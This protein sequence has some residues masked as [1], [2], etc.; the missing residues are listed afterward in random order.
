MINYSFPSAN[1]TKNKMKPILPSDFSHSKWTFP[2]ITSCHSDRHQPDNLPC[3][4]LV[5]VRLHFCPHLFSPDSLHSLL[6]VFEAG[7]S[8]SLHSSPSHYTSHA[9]RWDTHGPLRANCK[10]VRQRSLRSPTT[11]TSPLAFKTRTPIAPISSAARVPPPHIYICRISAFMKT[12]T[13]ASPIS[14]A[15]RMPPPHINTGRISA[16]MTWQS[17]WISREVGFPNCRPHH[18]N[19]HQIPALVTGFGAERSNLREVERL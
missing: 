2:N 7:Y 9:F 16:F 3:R 5:M 17:E 1:C 6:S 14:S 19:S 13:S 18:V 11:P 15:A 8:P 4:D 12:R 10:T